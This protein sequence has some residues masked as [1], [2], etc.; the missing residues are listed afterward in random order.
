MSTLL[1]FIYSQ[2]VLPRTSEHDTER[3]REREREKGERKREMRS[4]DRVSEDKKKR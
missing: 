3:K 4:I 2:Q 1:L